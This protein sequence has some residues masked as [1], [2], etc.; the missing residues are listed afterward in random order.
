MPEEFSLQG[1]EVRGEEPVGDVGEHSVRDVPDAAQARRFE[2]ERL[3]EILTPMPPITRGFSS[4]PPRFRRKSSM[5]A[6]SVL[7]MFTPFGWFKGVV[8][9]S[10]GFDG[11]SLGV[12]QA[13]PAAEPSC[14][15]QRFRLP[16]PVFKGGRRRWSVGCA[17]L[18]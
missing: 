2:R 6:E 5:V 17:V 12:P 15:R 1:G 4:V 14:S 16:H 10:M 8:G 3:V 11:V 9:V 13:F 7:T 18:P